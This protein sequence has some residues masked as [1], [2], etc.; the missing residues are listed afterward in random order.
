MRQWKGFSPLD[1]KHQAFIG[2]GSNVGNRADNCRNAI[3]ALSACEGC[4]LEAQSALYETEPVYLEDQNWFINCAALLRTCLEP[5]AVLAQLQAIEQGVGRSLDGPKYGPRVLDLDILFFDDLVLEVGQLQVPHPRLHER[6]F[7]LKPLCDI[8][9]EHVHP[10]LGRTVRSLLSGLDDG[11][12][13]VI[14]YK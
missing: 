5:E 14:L 4:R 6:R 7:V 2:L 8:A 11:E 9:P 1:Y 10:V 12:K 3:E 13:K